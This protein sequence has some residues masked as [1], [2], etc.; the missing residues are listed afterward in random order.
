M[1]MGTLDLAQTI[2]IFKQNF[3]KMYSQF[4]LYVLPEKQQRGG[5]LYREHHIGGMF[6]WTLFGHLT[7][8]SHKLQRTKIANATKFKHIMTKL[9]IV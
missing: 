4:P 9:H 2:T 7:T 5:L 6:F 1:S 3:C 8:K